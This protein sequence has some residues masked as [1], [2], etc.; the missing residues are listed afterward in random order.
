M[1]KKRY[2]K[3]IKNFQFFS[4][5]L[6]FNWSAWMSIVIRFSLYHN[7]DILTEYQLERFRENFHVNEIYKEMENV[8]QKNESG[9]FAGIN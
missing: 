2:R 4:L 7:F 9:K 6:S 1:E 3:K 5:P 8:E